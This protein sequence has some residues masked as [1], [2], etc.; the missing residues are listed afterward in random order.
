M[1]ANRYI[2]KSPLIEIF[3]QLITDIRSISKEDC[4]RAVT[5]ID[6]NFQNH[7]FRVGYSMKQL[8]PEKSNREKLFDGGLKK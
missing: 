4:Q 8:V 6:R 3:Q 7:R 1:T 2:P 5:V